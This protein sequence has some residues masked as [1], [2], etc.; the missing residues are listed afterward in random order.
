VDEFKPLARGA[1]PRRW[2]GQ[3]AL[4]PRPLRPGT[5]VIANKPSHAQRHNAARR[6]FR[7]DA[8]T[9]L[10]TLLVVEYSRPSYEN[11]LC[12]IADIRLFNV[13]RAVVLNDPPA[14]PGSA[15]QA[16]SAS[17]RPS[18]GGTRSASAKPG[19]DRAASGAPPTSAQIFRSRLEA[20]IEDDSDKEDVP[21]AVTAQ[22]TA[23]KVETSCT[24]CKNWLDSALDAH[25]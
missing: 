17:P 6:T 22:G 7:V 8:H 16:T 15:R 1:G 3:P 9:Y 18:G 20:K 4:V 12:P 21:V 11:A 5:G 19:G 2:G 24:P 25:K 14:R 23:A 10:R 13:G